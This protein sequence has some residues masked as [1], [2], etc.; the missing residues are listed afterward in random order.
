MRYLNEIYFQNSTKIL[1]GTFSCAADCILEMW[2]QKVCAGSTC[3][4]GSRFLSLLYDSGVQVCSN[5][6]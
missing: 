2:L 3:F 4:N 1:K 6:Y 5:K